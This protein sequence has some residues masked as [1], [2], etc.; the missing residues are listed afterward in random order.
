MEHR[1]TLYFSWRWT[2]KILD[3]SSWS[4]TILDTLA[5]RWNLTIFIT[6]LR[7]GIGAKGY[8][9]TAIE[10]KL[11]Y[12]LPG[13]EFSSLTTGWSWR[14]TSS[15][16]YEPRRLLFTRQR[17]TSSTTRSASTLGVFK[18]VIRSE[19]QSYS[20]LRIF[21]LPDPYSTLNLFSFASKL[22]S[23]ISKLLYFYCTSLDLKPIGYNNFY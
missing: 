17:P 14:L 15:R 5:W 7:H 6:V 22:L 4:Q 11:L 1:N 20:Q 13:F 23:L 8:F 18:K 3:T 19:S 12:S 2:Y 21:S 16:S 9:I 10:P